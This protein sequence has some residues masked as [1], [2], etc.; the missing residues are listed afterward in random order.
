MLF[1]L[2]FLL[3]CTDGKENNTAPPAAVTKP[4]SSIRTKSDTSIN[5]YIQV[6]ISPM[7]MSYYP[8]DYPKMKMAKATSSLPLA[9][10][11]YS[12]PHLQGRHVFHEV[13]KYDE[14]WRL[15]ANESMEFDLY[16]DAVIQGQKIK[17]CRYV[18]YCIPQPDEWTIILNSNI[19]SWGL[20]PDPAKDV[21]RFT[22]PVIKTNHSLEY[23]TMVFQQTGNGAG[24]LIAWDNVEVRLPLKF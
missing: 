9:R 24:L 18:L 22:V 5:P 11:I 14:P 23:F 4:D 12:R 6:D 7:D 21:A 8:V 17:S 10:V 15:G 3:S 13:L 19:D 16:N 1:L 2:P 20:Q